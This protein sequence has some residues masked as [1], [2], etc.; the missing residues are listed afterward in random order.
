MSVSDMEG[1]GLKT[2]EATLSP[3]ASSYFSVWQKKTY[4]VTIVVGWFTSNVAFIQSNM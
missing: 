1:S 4:C 3:V 2:I